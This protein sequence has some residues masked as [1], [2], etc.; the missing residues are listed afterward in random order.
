[1]HEIH[2]QIQ[3]L[4]K[5]LTDKKRLVRTE[6]TNND[7]NNCHL[8]EKRINHHWKLIRTPLPLNTVTGLQYQG[9]YRERGAVI[10][11]VS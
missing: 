5:D 2:C 8:E 9:P 11:Q 1:M 3:V 10:L 4:K 7:I 6:S